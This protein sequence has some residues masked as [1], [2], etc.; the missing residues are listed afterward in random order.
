LD[1]ILNNEIEAEPEEYEQIESKSTVNCDVDENVDTPEEIDL[2]AVI[3]IPSTLEYADYSK[4]N[5]SR[6]L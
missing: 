6:F 2:Q 5:I 3:I 1:T 4:S